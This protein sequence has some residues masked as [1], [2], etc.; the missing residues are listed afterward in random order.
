MRSLVSIGI[1]HALLLSAPHVNA[2][3][4]LIKE[5]SGDSFF[6]GWN[7]IDGYDNTTNGALL[8]VSPLRSRS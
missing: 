2:Q 4:Q 1:L 8:F 7:Y 5:Y 6:D 3:Y